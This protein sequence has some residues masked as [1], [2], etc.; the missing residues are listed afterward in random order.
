MNVLFVTQVVKLVVLV[1][2]LIVFHVLSHT[3]SIYMEQNVILNAQM[4]HILLL[5]EYATHVVL[6]VS[7]V[8]HNITITVYLAQLT[9]I[10]SVD[11]VITH[12]QQDITLII[13]LVA[14][15]LVPIL[16]IPVQPLTHVTLVPMDITYILAHVLIHAQVISDIM[17]ALKTKNVWNVMLLARLVSNLLQLMQTNV[18]GVQVTQ[19][20]TTEENVLQKVSVNSQ[21]QFVYTIQMDTMMFQ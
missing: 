11:H 13:L 21:A 9:T 5:M 6:N 20:V 18:N 10:Y 12:A 8:M 1:H 7:L 19:N 17:L 2:P 16:V 3:D 14:V 4:E 15:L